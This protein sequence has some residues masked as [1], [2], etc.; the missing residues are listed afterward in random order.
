MQDRDYLRTR[1]NPFCVHSTTVGCQSH[2]VS[3]FFQCLLPILTLQ[4]DDNSRHTMTM[5]TRLPGVH[6][7]NAVAP[8]PRTS[9]PFGSLNSSICLGLVASST[10][11][12][13][14][15]WLTTL[16]P[17]S[18]GCRWIS[19]HLTATNGV[20]LISQ[21]SNT[22]FATPWPSTPF[23]MFIASVNAFRSSPQKLNRTSPTLSP[24]DLAPSM[25]GFSKGSTK[26]SPPIVPRGLLLGG[27]LLTRSL[28]PGR[29]NFK[30]S[31]KRTY[32]VP[33]E[34]ILKN[35]SHITSHPGFGKP[36]F[37]LP[38]PSTTKISMLQCR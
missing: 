31:R 6:S 37:K 14:F 35:L 34:R 3:I 27:L 22:I 13:L 29:L 8:F 36:H 12:T 25:A 7:M 28:D 32:V 9:M 26:L 10:K 1:D 17:F 23:K 19:L 33:D 11:S 4:A 15:S 38:H 18:C 24:Q 20:L 30:N 5:M 21:D 2:S 16:K